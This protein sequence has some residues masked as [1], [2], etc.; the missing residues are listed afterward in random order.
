MT[1]SALLARQR[2]IE[3]FELRS[4][5]ADPYP[6]KETSVWRGCATTW[7]V[8]QLDVADAEV[9]RTPNLPSSIKGQ[10]PDVPG[11]R[12]TLRSLALA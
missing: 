1:D 5:R 12:R 4:V 3:E 7:S 10:G 6:R 8:L 9:L 2:S 11:Q